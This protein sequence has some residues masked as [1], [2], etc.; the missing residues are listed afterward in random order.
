MADVHVYY[1]NDMA[2]L[3]VPY[4][5]VKTL[6]IGSDTIL[7]LISMVSRWPGIDRSID[8]KNEEKK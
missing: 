4:T 6:D 5:K 3:T 2:F 1:Q 7:D 8:N